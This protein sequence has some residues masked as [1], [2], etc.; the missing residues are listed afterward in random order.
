MRNESES[1]KKGKPEGGKT[2]K[3][4]PKK[5]GGKEAAVSCRVKKKRIPRRGNQMAEKGRSRWD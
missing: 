5:R 2:I 3:P 4:E 1:P